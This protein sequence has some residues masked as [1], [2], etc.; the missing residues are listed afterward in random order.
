M[1]NL[2]MLLMA[3][4]AITLF[5]GQSFANETMMKSSDY[6][7]KQ[8]IGLNVN[9][10]DGAHVGKI[11]DVNLNGETGEIN[12]VILG[13]SLLGIGEDST[14]A[15]PLKALTIENEEGSITATLVV[16]KIRLLG[17]P[18]IITGESDEDFKDRLQKY[19]CA[20]PELGNGM[21]GPKEC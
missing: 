12:Y 15:I 14:Y 3:I 20:A 4:L 2:S 1:K 17:A 19:Y 13:K 5:S 9:N 16:S 18:S 8:L 21:Y 11:R 10:L 7:A 6:N